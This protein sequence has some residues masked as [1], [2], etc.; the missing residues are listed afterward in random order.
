MERWEPPVLRV[1]GPELGDF[2]QPFTISQ[3]RDKLDGAEKLHRVRVRPAQWPQL[4]GTDENGDIVRRAVQQLRH[5][6]RQ[7]FQ[8]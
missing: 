2:V 7:F 1:A 4:A 5:M 8:D 3:Q 6:S